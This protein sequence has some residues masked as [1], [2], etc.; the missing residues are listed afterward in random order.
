MGFVKT[1]H[2][3]LFAVC[4]WVLVIADLAACASAAPATETVEIAAVIE[5]T[6]EV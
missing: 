2:Q 1:I 4:A 6:Q 3:N 5:D